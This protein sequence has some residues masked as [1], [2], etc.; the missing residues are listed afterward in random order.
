M[1]DEYDDLIDAVQQALGDA[2][3][4]LQSPELMDELRSALVEMGAPAPEGKP[5]LRVVD[6]DDS[7]E[8]PAPSTTVRTVK[9]T[10]PLRSS[11]ST[12]HEGQIAV[13]KGAWQ[14]VFR[15][16]QSRPYR[17]AVDVGA[18]DIAVDGELVERI[19]PGQTVDVE[20]SLVRVQGAVA[21]SGTYRRL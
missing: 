10:Q 14:T 5:N 21:S 6:A 9:L 12:A 2:G 17:V 3:V 15:G 4:N 16:A 7:D 13:K 11:T 18:L 8:P 1:S 20:G 19:G